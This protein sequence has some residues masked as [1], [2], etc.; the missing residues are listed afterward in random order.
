MRILLVWPRNPRAV[1]S[2]QLSCCEPLPLEYLAGALRDHHDVRIV[3]L[4]LD[5]PLAEWAQSHE[6][7]DLVGVAVPYTTNVHVARAVTKEAKRLWPD[8]PLMIGGHH[9]TVSTEWLDGFAADWVVAGE[10]AG[11]VRHLVA[12]LEAGQPVLPTIGLAP[13]QARAELRRITK[14]APAS[15]NELPRPDRTLL[16]HHREDY[17]H[18]IYRPVALARFSAGCPYQCNFCSLWRM[19]DRRYLVKE[20]ERIVGELNDI[21]NRNIYVVDDEAFIQPQRM[22]ELA[23]AIEQDGL[24]K[25]YHM[26]VR[27]DTATR[28]PDVITRWAQVGLDSVLI[29]AESMTDNELDGYHKGTDSGQ[30]RQA[31]DLFHGLGVKVRAN[32]IVRPGWD[33]ADFDRLHRTIDELGVDMPSFSV[34]TPLPG[35]DLYDEVR[36]D[37]IS[38]DPELFDC[39]HTLFPTRLDPARFYERVAGL[40]LAA[41]NRGGD[42]D[43]PGVFYFSTD[44]AFGRMVESV[45]Q[46]HLLA[47]PQPA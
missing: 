7:P 4:R 31:M 35:T 40:L 16:A 41:S 14:P 42:G 11:P 37:L 3:D 5:P 20:A 18:S 1:L 27:T 34:L 25:R 29:G 22:L 28:R 19:T 46:G 12:A 17:F 26:Y 13:Y 45:R 43:G 32:F 38:D 33:D 21:P 8:V 6:A 39:Y 24:D 47:E 44:D 30:T 9:P 36:H 2:D 15:L 23:D 10:G